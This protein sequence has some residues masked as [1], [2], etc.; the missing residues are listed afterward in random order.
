MYIKR[1]QNKLKNT[2]IVKLKNNKPTQ[3]RYRVR[4]T[5]GSWRPKGKPIIRSKIYIYLFR[6]ETKSLSN[7]QTF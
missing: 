3:C 5:V 2:S 6:T 7:V 4:H 1:Q